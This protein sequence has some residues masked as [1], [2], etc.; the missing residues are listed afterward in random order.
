MITDA[1]DRLVLSVILV[2]TDRLVSDV[3]VR[4]GA[5]GGLTPRLAVGLRGLT[6]MRSVARRRPRSTSVT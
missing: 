1:A 6:C 3:P 5:G 2:H 4:L